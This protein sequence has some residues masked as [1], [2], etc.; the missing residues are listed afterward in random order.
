MTNR[1]LVL[2]TGAGGRIGRALADKLSDKYRVVGLDLPAVA[3]AEHIYGCDITDETSVARAI[4][5]IKETAGTQVAVVVHL[6][7]YFD[8]S[9]KESPQYEAVNV[10]GTRNLLKGLAALDV[11]HFVYSGTMLV[12]E[13]GEPGERIDETAAINPGWAYPESKARTEQVIR[14]VAPDL[15]PG[16]SVLLLHLAGLYDD[17]TAVPTLSHQIA[18]IYERDM[19]SHAYSGDLRA[20]Q[21]VIHIDDMLDLFQRAIDR[22]DNI[23]GIETVLAGEPDAIGYDRLQTAIG[24]LIHGEVSWATLTVP[25]TFAKAAAAVQVAAEPPIPDAFDEG[26][27]PFIKPFMIDLSSDHYALDISK[28][29]SLLNWEPK[30]SILE[31]LEALVSNL[32]ADPSRWY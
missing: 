29:R 16:M 4:S 10:E 28:A 31:G 13:A 5:E 22:R 17:R 12:H 1:E 3:D 23:E 19:K 21:S 32:K 7:A 2:I 18:R 9:G 25:P 6:A 27:K 30:H 15:H 14:D 8:F 11:D 20:G 24:K 26:E